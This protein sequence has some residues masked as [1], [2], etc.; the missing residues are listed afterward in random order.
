[1]M[2][3]WAQGEFLH[4]TIHATLRLWSAPN[5]VSQSGSRLIMPILLSFSIV[6]AGG[7]RIVGGG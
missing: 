6:E 3:A 1:M 2:N 4:L 5:T 7:M